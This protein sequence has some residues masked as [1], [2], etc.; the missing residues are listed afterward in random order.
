MLVAPARRLRI[1]EAENVLAQH[2]QFARGRP[3]DGRDHVQ[4]RRLA[5]ARRPHQRQEFALRDLDRNVVERLHFK[6][7][8]LENLADVARLDD[9]GAGRDIG[10]RYQCS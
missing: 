2:Q 8:A 7:I 3:V 5:R 4:Q 6:R 10:L 9:F 1:A